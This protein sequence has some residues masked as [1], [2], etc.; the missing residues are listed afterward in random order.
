MKKLLSIL[1][2]ALAAL[3]ASAQDDFNPTLPGEPN[4]QYKVTVSIS[5]AAAGTV[6]GGG[7]YNEGQQVTIK[8]TDKSVSASSTVFYK[9][10]YW[11]LNGFEYEPAGTKTSFIY[12]IGTENAAFEAVYEEQDPDEVTSKVFLVA[13]PADA[14]T[15]N[16]TSGQRYMEGTSWSFSYTV[17][18]NA[19]RFLGWYDQNGTQLSTSKSYGFEIGADDVTLTARFAYEPV[20]PID[21]TGSQDNVANG[22]L[23]DVNGDG[24]VTVADAVAVMNYYLHWTS[25]SDDDNKYDINRDSKITVADAVNVMNIYLTAQ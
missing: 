8:R 20:V 19:F 22:L 13:E 6:S 14:C 12:N 17:A 11:T 16:K 23:G 24:K 18:S 15:F 1:L 5:P 25:T 3:S 2:L 7:S 10:K 9:F 21:P 4:A